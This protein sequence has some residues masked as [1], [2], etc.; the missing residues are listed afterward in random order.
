MLETLRAR[1]AENAARH[2]EVDWAEVEVRLLAQPEAVEKL[3][4]MESTGGQPDVIGRDAETG[5]LILCDC[6]PESPVGRRSL[7]YDEEALMNRKKNP[8]AGCAEKQARE[9]GV[10]LMPEALYRRLQELGEFDRRTSS[11][12]LTPEDVRKQGGALF[13]ERKYGRVFT[14]HNGAESYYS[15]RGWRGFFLL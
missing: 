3:R 9:M 11:W 5:R 4:R 2:P 7:C 14:F 12:I 13:C 1:F 15:V 6:S 10:E 8:P